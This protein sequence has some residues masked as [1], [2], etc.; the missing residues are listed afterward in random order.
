[1]SIL[2]ILLFSFAMTLI[3]ELIMGWLWGIREKDGIYVIFLVNLI[4]NPPLVLGKICFSLFLPRE[5]VG[6]L[7]LAAEGGI[8]ILEGFLYHKRLK[9][10][11][12]PYLFAAAANVL[13]YGAG[14]FWN[15]LNI[16]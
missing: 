5:T 9:S 1:M 7:V 10:C 16:L 3:L 8:W 12:H 4:T 6:Y 14:V 2:N 11:R 13:S 15:Y